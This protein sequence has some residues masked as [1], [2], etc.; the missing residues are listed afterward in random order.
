MP[1]TATPMGTRAGSRVTTNQIGFVTVSIL[2]ERN[3]RQGET[4]NARCR[5]APM[6]NKN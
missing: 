3:V 6:A 2:L 5:A 1:W 4:G